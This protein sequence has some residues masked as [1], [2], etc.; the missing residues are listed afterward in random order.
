[1][2]TVLR[3]WPGP[4]YRTFKV[5]YSDTSGI[6][7]S[8]TRFV[9]LPFN[10]DE[11]SSFNQILDIRFRFVQEISQDTVSVSPAS[12]RAWNNLKKKSE[13]SFLRFKF[14]QNS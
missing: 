12:H 7:S 2:V 13:I 5:E 3:S 9:A 14:N 6:G 8:R 4:D 1:M 11:H 10:F